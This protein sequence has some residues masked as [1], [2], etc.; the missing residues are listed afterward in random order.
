MKTFVSCHA[1]VALLLLLGSTSYLVDG[2]KAGTASFVKP[3]SYLDSQVN[4]DAAFLPQNS[5]L[6]SAVDDVRGGGV[7]STSSSLVGS[8]L[9]GPLFGPISFIVLNQAFTKIFKDKGISFPA[10]LGGCMIMFLT[11]T[12]GEIIKPGFGDAI[13]A[14]LGPG[15]ATLAKWLPVFF[16]PAMVALPLSPSVGG[17]KEIGKV[18]LTTAVGV[19]FTLYSTALFVLTLRKIMGKTEAA[20]DASEEEPAKNPLDIIK[21]FLDQSK[22]EVAAPAPPPKAFSDEFFDGLLKSSITLG[23]LSIANTKLDVLGGFQKPIETLFLTIATITSFVFG[24]R[25]P[26]GFRAVIHPTLVATGLASVLVYVNGKITGKSSYID[27]LKSFKTGSVADITATG[28]GDLLFYMLGPAVVSFSQAM[29]ARRKLLVENLLVVAS[30]ILFGSFGALFGTAAFARL[31]NLGGNVDPT[32]RLSVLSRSV[33]APLAV[34]VSDM[35][36]G[37]MGITAGVV[38]ITGISVASFGRSLLDAAGIKDPVARGMGQGA[39]GQSLGTAAIA[40]EGEAFPFAAM[41]FVFMAVVTTCITVIPFFKD[42]VIQ[43]ATGGMEVAVEAAA[44]TIV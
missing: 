41:T 29:Y 14:A 25:L 42:L 34:V 16:A 2:K 13:N 4:R 6:K 36:G 44:E 12:V 38:V 15:A 24:S 27:A 30:G 22:K 9:D 35:L 1:I 37:N 39:A 32:L 28:A 43:V 19:C 5:D 20:E 18:L 8:L 26:A 17:P 7:A 31:I 11:M 21:D 40:S 3:K 23:L 10:P 33:T